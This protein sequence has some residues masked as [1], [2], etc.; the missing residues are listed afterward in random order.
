MTGIVGNE[1]F[2]SG[3]L[4]GFI[5]GASSI[6]ELRVNAHHTNTQSGTYRVPFG[7]LELAD[8]NDYGWDASEKG[9]IVKKNGFYLMMFHQN[10]N[11]CSTTGRQDVTITCIGG[12]SPGIDQHCIHQ[13]SSGETSYHV[14]PVWGFV[15]L[16]Q[17][18]KTFSVNYSTSFSVTY[19]WHGCG[20]LSVYRLN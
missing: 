13:I 16:T 15:N 7:V 14:R 11:T 8:E 4:D 10:W 19:F 18:P 12:H 6:G 9:I 1:P 5:R 20:K 2:N 17:A 3:M